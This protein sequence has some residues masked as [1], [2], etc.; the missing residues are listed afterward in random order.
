MLLFKVTVR[1]Y[2]F[3]DCHY[4]IICWPQ[5][6]RSSFTACVL[7]AGTA[8]L[9]LQSHSL[10]PSVIFRKKMSRAFVKF[11]TSQNGCLIDKGI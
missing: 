3:D 6:Q 1:C 8:P 11:I 9:C 5:V 2:I 4:I 10:C 7:W